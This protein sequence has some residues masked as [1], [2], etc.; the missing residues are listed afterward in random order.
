MA[1]AQG[2]RGMAGLEKLPGARAVD[3]ILDAVVQSC[4]AFIPGVRQ[5]DERACCVGN[6]SEEAG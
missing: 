2:V 3:F 5:S 1:G 6:G 4:R